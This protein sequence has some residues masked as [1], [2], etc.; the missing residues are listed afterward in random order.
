MTNHPCADTIQRLAEREARAEEQR[1]EQTRILRE[2]NAALRNGLRDDMREQTSRIKRLER[3]A[4]GLL[5]GAAMLILQ[6]VP[7]VWTRF[8]EWLKP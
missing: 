4:T 7:S 2:I 3:V 1:E 8:I 5:V 6:E